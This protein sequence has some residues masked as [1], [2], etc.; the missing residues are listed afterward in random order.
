MKKERLILQVV[1]ILLFSAAVIL[2]IWSD[3]LE[4]LY[5][6]DFSGV[7][8]AFSVHRPTWEVRSGHL[9]LAGRDPGGNFRI[10]YGRNSSTSFDLKLGDENSAL[11]TT[12]LWSHETSTGHTVGIGSEG[13]HEHSRVRGRD[14][15]E[16]F[17]GYRCRP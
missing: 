6:T 14:V 16:R 12:L 7:D 9:Y 1:F 17:T 15:H 2:P 3:D 11:Q 4:R 13:V 8:D 5:A 10:P